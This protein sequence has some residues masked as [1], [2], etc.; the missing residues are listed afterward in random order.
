[1]S[2]IGIQISLLNTQEDRIMEIYRQNDR[3]VFNMR[4]LKD[5]DESGYESF[6]ADASEFIEAMNKI[7]K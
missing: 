5:G 6:D 1:M 7:I 4:P 3:I 2:R